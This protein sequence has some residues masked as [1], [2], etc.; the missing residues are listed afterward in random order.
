VTRTSGGVGGREPRGS[1]L[2]RLDVQRT[3]TTV[4]KL[5]INANGDLEAGQ[6]AVPPTVYLDHWALR[7]FSEDQEWAS[8]LTVA[9]SS[10]EGTLALSWANLAEFTKVTDQRQARLAGTLIEA[11]LPRIFLLEVNPFTVIE[12]EDHL[13]AGGP[14]VPPHGDQD[15]LRALVM[16]KPRA[17]TLFTAHNLFTAV[18]RPGS[19]TRADSMADMFVSRLATMRDEIQGDSTLRAALG[20]PATTVPIQRGTRFILQELVRALILDKGTKITCNDAFDFFHAVV[21]VAYCDF[22]LLDGYWETQV[23]RVRSRFQASDL[24]VP[25]AIVFSRRREG[26]ERFIQQLEQA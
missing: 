20:R 4:V 22:V 14:P 13:L 26:I 5:S 16:L 1:P 10:Q 24:P 23:N 21:P 7:A 2:S 25:M 17:L 18:Q 11:N 3:E 15:F 8:R 12:R 6:Q 19:V 9:L